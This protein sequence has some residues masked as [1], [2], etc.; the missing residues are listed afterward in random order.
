M[1][2]KISLYTEPAIGSSLSYLVDPVYGNVENIE[3]VGKLI[4]QA[5]TSAAPFISNQ[6]LSTLVGSFDFYRYLDV[7]MLQKYLRDNG[8][9]MIVSQVTSEIEMPTEGVFVEVVSPCVDEL[10]VST[11]YYDP[12]NQY[13]I[14]RIAADQVEKLNIDD[15]NLVPESNLR[16]VIKAITEMRDKGMSV[17]PMQIDQVGN[18]MVDRGFQFYYIYI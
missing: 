3:G 5:I 17:F 10:P 18:A 15:P 8:I 4:K 2:V 9:L 13:D 12:E 6:E 14:V 11:I 1:K 16:S 7:Q